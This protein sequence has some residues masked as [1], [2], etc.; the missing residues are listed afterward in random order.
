MTAQKYFKIE[1]LLEMLKSSEGQEPTLQEVRDR[2]AAYGHAAPLPNGWQAKQMYL[3][4]IPSLELTGPEATN[5]GALLFFHAG[6]Y[7]SGSA[8]DHAGLAAELGRAAKVKSYCVDYRLAPE[9]TFPAAIEDSYNAYL[10]LN[11]LVGNH[12]P[13][14]LAGDSAGGGIAIAVTQM[15]KIRGAKAPSAVYAISPWAN[16]RQVGESYIQRSEFDPLLSK[17]ALEALKELYL[18]GYNPDDPMASP[19]LGDFRNFPPLLVHVGANEVLLSDALKV[20]ELS[21]MAGNDVSLK[22]WRDMIHIFPWFYPHLE[23]ANLAIS[24]A[25]K[26]LEVNLNKANFASH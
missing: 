11:G 23:E 18:D 21:A 4:D 3:G 16:L 2:Q 6:G 22:V 1:N 5:S 17:K 13:I 26:W 7:S 19:I 25:G 24:A 14:A 20:T 10:S 8:A 9:H 15:A 12:I